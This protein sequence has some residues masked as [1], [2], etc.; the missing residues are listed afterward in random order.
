MGNCEGA[1]STVRKI[2]GFKREVEQTINQSGE[3]ETGSLER[4]RMENSQP[5]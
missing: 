1:Y 2:M 4:E 5:N 3:G